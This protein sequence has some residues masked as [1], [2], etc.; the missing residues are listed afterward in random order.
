M[1]WTHCFES[2]SDVSVI[3]FSSTDASSIGNGDLEELPP[4]HNQSSASETPNGHGSIVW[5]LCLLL[6][7]LG[8]I[9]LLFA[10]VIQYFIYT[11][12][13]LR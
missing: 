8:F 5:G 4:F 1:L 11:C 7:L 2:Q 9:T 10:S 3:N 12:R 13:Y 6:L